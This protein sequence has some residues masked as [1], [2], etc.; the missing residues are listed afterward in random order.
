MDKNIKRPQDII[1]KKKKKR[2]FIAMMCL[3]EFKFL[4]AF[5]RFTKDVGKCHFSRENSLLTQY[6]SAERVKCVG[7]SAKG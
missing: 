6:S 7:I 1:I 2:N 3:S 5:L 4:F